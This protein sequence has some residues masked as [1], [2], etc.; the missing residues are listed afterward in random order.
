GGRR[1]LPRPRLAGGGA[2]RD[3]E[4]GTP[5][6]TGDNATLSGVTC[7]SPDSCL[8]VG[9]FVATAEGGSTF[10][11]SETWNGH[12]W[13]TITVSGLTTK[14]AV[15]DALEVS[16]GAPGSCMLVGEHFSNPRLP[17]QFADTL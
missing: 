4:A 13:G 17:V 15:T 2:G 8:A 12:N 1:G 11:L 7:L 14:A 3:A 6:I 10:G 5:A 16:C 9:S